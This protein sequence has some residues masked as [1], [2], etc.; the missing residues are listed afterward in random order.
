MA[1]NANKIRSLIKSISTRSA[2]QR[3][4]IQEAL[5]ECALFVFEDRNTDPAIR[6]FGAIGGETHRAGMSKWLSLNAAVHF[7]EG[8]PLL[9]DERQK[10]MVEEL[11]AAEYEERIRSMPAWF[12]M[13]EDNNKATNVWDSALQIK[14]LDEYLM[15]QVKQFA[16]HDSAIAE[17]LDRIH[18][19]FRAQIAKVADV[20]EV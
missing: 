1:R 3:S 13:D 15:K 14:K 20:V 2:K 10:E 9:S 18:N 7:K 6:L 16:K 19:E 11:T 17:T 8:K 12:D 4:D 5:V